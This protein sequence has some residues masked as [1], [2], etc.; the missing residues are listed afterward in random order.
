[1]LPSALNS[2]WQSTNFQ[3]LVSN[4]TVSKDVVEQVVAPIKKFKG[5]SFQGVQKSVPGNKLVQLE[6]N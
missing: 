3:P 4:L 6:V 2:Y 5:G 1:M